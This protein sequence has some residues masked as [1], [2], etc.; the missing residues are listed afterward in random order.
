MGEP[1]PIIRE[2]DRASLA[3]RAGCPLGAMLAS[4]S[5]HEAAEAFGLHFRAE[6]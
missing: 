3:V 6:F 4:E 5:V 2:L 1:I